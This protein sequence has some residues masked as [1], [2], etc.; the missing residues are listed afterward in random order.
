MFSRREVLGLVSFSIILVLAGLV[1]LAFGGEILVRSA[2]RIAVV[3]GVSPLVIG[4]TIVAYG[5]SAP[6]L[7]VSLFASLEGNPAIAVTNV[8]GSNIF[9]VCFILG[10]CA[11]ISPL[12]VNLQLL[13]LDVPIL[14]VTSVLAMIFCLDG[15][16]SLYE[17]LTLTTGA[18]VYT[19]WLI[20]SS[21]N[22]GQAVKDEFAEAISPAG[23]EDRGKT[24]LS[25]SIFCLI[26]LGVLLAGSKLLVQGATELAKV[27]GVSDRLIGLTIVAAGTSLPE[28]A[29]S[30][31]A[32][33]RGQRDI[34]VGNIIGSNIFNLM[35][36]LGLSSLFSDGGLSVSPSLISFDIPIMVA[37][38]FLIFPLLWTSRKLV[39]WEGGILFLGYVG[40]GVAL[41]VRG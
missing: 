16:V 11:L 30:I 31:M 14:I 20:Q 40:Y 1:L 17:G 12:V 35:L 19:Y 24:L 25:Q 10:L 21:R 9:N 2:S 27:V 3:L 18:I 28:V 8:V 26:S 23:A 38:V 37:A 6:E 34:A 39:R 4:L 7:G 32:T 22:E 33:I 41:W 36:I 29:T 13:K 15:Q 5:T